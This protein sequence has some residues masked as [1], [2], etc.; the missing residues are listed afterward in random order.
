MSTRLLV[1]ASSVSQ[2]EQN[3]ITEWFKSSGY[4]W[5]HYL[6]NLWIVRDPYNRLNV[7]SIAANL[8]LFLPGRHLVVLDMEN[9]RDCD[10]WLPPNAWNWLKDS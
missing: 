3:Q 2:V 1:C 8:R 5:W 7:V 4:N 10:G 9:T 6:P